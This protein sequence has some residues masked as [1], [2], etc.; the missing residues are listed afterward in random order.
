MPP[1]FPNGFLN[2]GPTDTAHFPQSHYPNCSEEGRCYSL[3]SDFLHSDSKQVCEKLL[4]FLN[5]RRS[6]MAFKC[7]V[8]L[9]D[10]LKRLSADVKP[11]QVRFHRRIRFSPQV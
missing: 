3:N 11:G 8:F 6:K 9:V 10:V 2:F 1:Q 4:A 7:P 5:Q